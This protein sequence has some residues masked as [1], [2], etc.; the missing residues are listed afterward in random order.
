M[1][2]NGWAINISFLWS[3]GKALVRYRRQSESKKS[4]ICKRMES[5]AAGFNHLAP[6]ERR[7]F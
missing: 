6:T 3:E 1:G 7:G 5:F 2:D 4:C